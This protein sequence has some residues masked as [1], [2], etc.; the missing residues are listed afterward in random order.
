L[1]KKETVGFLI[2]LLQIL[3]DITVL[4]SKLE[5]EKITLSYNIHSY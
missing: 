4:P 3:K 1:T 5:M 2:W